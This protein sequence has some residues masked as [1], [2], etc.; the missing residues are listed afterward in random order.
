MPTTFF[1]FW[2]DRSQLAPNESCQSLL[3]NHS[4]RFVSFNG[5]ICFSKL[6]EL[7]LCCT[8]FQCP[9]NL[10][11]LV[12]IVV[13]I[14]SIACHHILEEIITLSTNHGRIS[15]SCAWSELRRENCQVDMDRVSCYISDR[16]R[17]SSGLRLFIGSP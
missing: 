15:I 5:S 2:I 17:K 7:V 10:N 1:Q 14:L 16:R 11:A 9:S 6:A 4:D 8:L 12:S 3:Q 13:L